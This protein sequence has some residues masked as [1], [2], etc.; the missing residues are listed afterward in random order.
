MFLHCR[1]FF[2]FSVPCGLKVELTKLKIVPSPAQVL[3][4]DYCDWPF[5]YFRSHGPLSME[6]SL[7]LCLQA[8][9]HK[10]VTS[11]LFR[12]SSLQCSLEL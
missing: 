10:L 4:K 5:V 9:V 7:S 12:R 11:Q 8:R 1:S 6:L 2:S 3:S